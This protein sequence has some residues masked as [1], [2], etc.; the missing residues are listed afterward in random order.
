MS[1]CSNQAAAAGQ[2]T[3]VLVS[4]VLNGPAVPTKIQTP[5]DFEFCVF[6]DEAIPT[7]SRNMTSFFFQQIP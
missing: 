4:E 1:D 2:W 3:L 7:G 5:K 6:F